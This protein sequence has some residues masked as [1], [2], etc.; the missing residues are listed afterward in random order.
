VS[1]AALTTKQLNALLLGEHYA[2]SMGLA[3]LRFQ[4][5]ERSF[6]W[7]TGDRGAAAV[8]G[9]GLRAAMARAVLEREGYAVAL[10]GS[11]DCEFAVDTQSS[12]WRVDLEDGDHSGAD[13]ASLA[14]FLRGRRRQA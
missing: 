3:V 14:A 1:I 13:F 10:D 6:K 9:S 8:R 11:S 7:L 4:S 12:G 5:E 2:R